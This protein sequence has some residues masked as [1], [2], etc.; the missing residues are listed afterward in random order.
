MKI[1][2]TSIKSIQN[3]SIDALAFELLGA[4]EEL[5]DSEVQNRLSK[6]I[7]V[8]NGDHMLNIWKDETGQTKIAIQGIGKNVT[9]L[10]LAA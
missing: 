6:T 8:D 4:N 2:S 1:E 7:K 3:I 5:P 9:L 10:T